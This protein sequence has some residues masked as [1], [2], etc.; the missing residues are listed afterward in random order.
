MVGRFQLKLAQDNASSK[1]LF[2]VTL[3]YEAD[4]EILLLL[5]SRIGAVYLIIVDQQPLGR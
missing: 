5:A 1:E 2:E 3:S 4:I